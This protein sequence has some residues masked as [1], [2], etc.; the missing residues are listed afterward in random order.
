LDKSHV[1]SKIDLNLPQRSNKKYKNMKYIFLTITIFL[2]LHSVNADARQ[3]LT[4]EE[5]YMRARENY[6]LVKQRQLIGKTRDYSIENASAAWLP[7][8]SIN[9]QATYQ[10]DVTQI[11]IKLPNADIP[12]LSKDQYKIYGDISQA[13]YDGGQTRI[14]KQIMDASAK[15]E[16]QKL[17]VELYKLKERINQLFF[18]ILMVDAQLGQNELLQNDIQLGIDKAAAAYANGVVLRSNVD[19]L[20]AELLK[21]G[22]RTTELTATRRAYLDMLGQFINEVLDENTM[23]VKPAIP[24]ASPEVHRPELALYDNQSLSIALRNK[25]IEARKLPKANLF[26]Q[27][28]YGRPALNMLSNDLKPYAIG[29]VRFSWSLSA[30]YTDRKERALVN[31]DRENIEVQRQTFLFNTGLILKQQNRELAKYGELI[32]S[33][34]QIILLRSDIKSSS[35]AQLDNGVINTSDYLREVNAEDQ[36]RQNRILHELQMLNAA[37]NQQITTGN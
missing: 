14:Q 37:Y 26:L 35:M 13:L 34:D 7:Q 33:D 15:V 25:T 23:L 1:E 3:K 24:S 9:G 32:S 12:V 2:S 30:F 29:G 28:G 11:P 27:G 22:Q 8:V 19:I 4:L 16:E 20:K 21:A 6:P 10:S 17:E 5:C 31:I 18:G 36:A